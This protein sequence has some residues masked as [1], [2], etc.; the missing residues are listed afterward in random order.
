MCEHEFIQTQGVKMGYS[1]N[2]YGRV[3]TTVRR[4]VCAKCYKTQTEIELETALTAANARIAELEKRLELA[5]KVCSSLF[6]DFCEWQLDVD[7]LKGWQDKYEKQ[8]LTEYEAKA[9]L[10]G[11]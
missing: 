3:E 7:A 5:E 6:T 2:D 1:K 8:Y 10:E 11:K 4:K 9:A